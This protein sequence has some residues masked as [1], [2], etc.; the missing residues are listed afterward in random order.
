M[1]SEDKKK[2]LIEERSKRRTEMTAKKKAKLFH[3]EDQARLIKVSGG[4][5]GTTKQPRISDMMGLKVKPEQ[6]GDKKKNGG[7][8]CRRG[9]FTSLKLA[10]N[11]GANRELKK[12]KPIR[13][14][15]RGWNMKGRGN[16]NDIRKY[17]V[18]FNRLGP[19]LVPT[20]YL[21]FLL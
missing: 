17:L 19:Y 2:I 10:S 21:V 4:R 1:R 8:S 9:I 15:V 5:A 16:I 6:S 7:S 3:V 13:A 14:S 18:N 12:L 11:Q 20:F